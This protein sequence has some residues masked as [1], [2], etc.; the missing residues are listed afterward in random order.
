MSVMHEKPERKRLCGQARWYPII[1][2]ILFASLFLFTFYYF[3]SEARRAV[4]SIIA[5]H[6]TELLS[7]FRRIHQTCKIS[8]LDLEK[9]PI[10]FLNVQSFVGSD[11]GSMNL[12]YPEGWE[13]PYAPINFTIQGRYYYILKSTKG[14]YIVPGDGVRLSNGKVIGRDIMLTP[15]IDIENLLKYEPGLSYRGIPLIAKLE[16]SHESNP[17]GPTEALAAQAATDT[18]EEW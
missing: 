17:S 7:I 10:N 5:D 11:V 13:G 1:L 2:G 6:I 14:Y 15:S 16:L 12:A 8:K 4:N 3:F 18:E 9:T